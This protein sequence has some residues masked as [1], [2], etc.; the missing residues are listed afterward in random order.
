[1]AWTISAADRT[2]RLV[3]GAHQRRL[4]RDGDVVRRH[5]RPGARRV[6]CARR[7]GRRPAGPRAGAHRRGD[8]VGGGG[9]AGLVE[10]VAVRVVGVLAGQQAHGGAGLAA[11]AGLLDAPVLEAQAEAVAVL[12]EDL[13]EVAAVPQRALDGGVE[14]AGVERGDVHQAPPVNE[15][16]TPAASGLQLGGTRGRERRA[17]CGAAVRQA[18]LDGRR[19]DARRAPAPPRRVPATRAAASGDDGDACAPSLCLLRR[20]TRRRGRCAGRTAGADGRR[21]PVTATM[22]AAVGLEHGDGAAV[23]RHD[24][25]LEAAVAG[26]PPRGGG[27]LPE[28][29]G[30]LGDVPSRRRPGRGATTSPSASSTAT[31]VMSVETSS[32]SRMASSTVR[33]S[34]LRVRMRPYD[35]PAARLLSRLA[36][37]R[38]CRAARSGRRRS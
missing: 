2:R 38:T 22:R 26:L 35:H 37:A 25:V 33:A 14:Q 36:R 32:R 20:R 13:G 17:S 30:R 28:P 7:R 31:R 11:A 5:A 24:D 19:R 27:R 6:G 8:G 16:R 34:S 4:A 1:M 10:R 18:E 3:A 21:G 9:Q 12:D 23:L 29:A 15:S